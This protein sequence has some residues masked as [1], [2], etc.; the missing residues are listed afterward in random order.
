MKSTFVTATIGYA[1]IVIGLG[2]LGFLALL[3]GIEPLDGDLN[4]LIPQMASTYLPPF[5][6]GLFFIMVIGSLSSTADSDLSALSALVMTDVYGKNIAKGKPNPKTML[7]VGRLTMVLATMLAMIFAS[8]KL[9]ILT[10]LIFV[11]ALWGAIVFPV[12]ASLYWERITNAAFTSAAIAGFVMFLVARFEL[13]EMQ[14]LVA[15]FFEGCAS[16]GGGVVI[17]LMA[18]GFLGKRAGFVL[19]ALA[20]MVFAPFAFGFLRDYPVLLSSLTAYGVSTVVCVL[21]SLRSNQTFDFDCINERVVAFH[22]DAEPDTVNG[23]SPCP[24]SL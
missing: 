12:I 4:N 8:M 21:V 1:S 7:F 19:G 9:D 5:A 2:M 14:G 23:A 13:L 22:H 18:F 11:G 16:I 10:M 20:F 15:L 17:G 6:V 3:A 24:V